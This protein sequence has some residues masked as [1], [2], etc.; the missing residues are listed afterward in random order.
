VYV[1]VFECR[2]VVVAKINLAVY[3][4]CG[5]HLNC[6]SIH[7]WCDDIVVCAPLRSL[8]SVCPVYVVLRPNILT[9]LPLL[10]VLAR[11]YD[12][13]TAIRED[14]LWVGWYL[15]DQ[16]KDETDTTPEL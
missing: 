7:K 6:G 3:A 8:S 5:N 13:P 10:L 2:G 9:F 4:D 12:S 14:S 16:S 11:L 15:Q 1:P